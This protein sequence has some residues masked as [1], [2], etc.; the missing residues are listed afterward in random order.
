MEK[1][2]FLGGMEEEL[3]GFREASMQGGRPPCQGWGSICRCTWIPPL[4]HELCGGGIEGGCVADMFVVEDIGVDR[5]EVMV[6]VDLRHD[7]L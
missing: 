3:G 1:R 5:R 4:G 2:V 6:H 7:R